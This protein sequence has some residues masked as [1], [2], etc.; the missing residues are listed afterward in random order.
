MKKHVRQRLLALLLTCA[1][2]LGL[3]PAALAAPADGK[4][5][6]DASTQWKYL[7]DL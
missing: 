7:D 4:V 3:C 5:L 2:V 1:M 6:I